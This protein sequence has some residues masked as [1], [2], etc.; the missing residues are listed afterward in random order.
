MVRLAIRPL[1]GAL[2]VA[3]WGT[4]APMVPATGLAAQ[5]TP[6]V[7]QINC[8]KP[9][10]SRV[11]RHR[12]ATGETIE[13]IAQKYKLIPAT[14][15]GMNPVLQK[16]TAPV[17]TEILVP[18]YNGIRVELTPGQTLPE[19]AKRYGIRPDVLFE[20]NGCQKNPKVV[21]VPGVNWTPIA[22]SSKAPQV[23]RVLNGSPFAGEITGNRILLNYG[24]GLQPDTGKVGFHSGIDLAAPAGTPVLAVADGTVAYAGEEGAYGRL[25]VINHQEGLQTRYAQL[26]K[27]TVKAGQTVKQGDSIGTVGSSGR[28]SSRAVH[29]HFEVR[30]RSNLGWVAENPANYLRLPLARN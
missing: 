15:I 22:S 16:G 9:A 2:G 12:I 21:F 3:V 6:V 19:L 5:T 24:W 27:V 23:T 20:V 11:T 13:R 4:I 26:G 29:L 28:P 17:G 14:L 7:A 1:V 25:I 30:S 8:P 18:P 10:L